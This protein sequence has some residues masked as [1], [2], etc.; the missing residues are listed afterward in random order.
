[1]YIWEQ[2]LSR[3]RCKKSKISSGISD[4]LTKNC[5]HFH[6]I[7]HLCI[8]FIKIRSNSPPLLCF[9]CSLSLFFN[10]F[11]KNTHEL[12]DMLKRAPL[13]TKTNKKTQPRKAAIILYQSNSSVVLESIRKLKVQ[14][15]FTHFC[16]YLILLIPSFTLALAPLYYSKKHI[17]SCLQRTSTAVTQIPLCISNFFWATS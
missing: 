17:S 6:W 16:K 12:Q 4:E 7:R 14:S 2:L 11:N 8:R 5:N 1:M 13:H 9:S 3:M 15:G 10:Y